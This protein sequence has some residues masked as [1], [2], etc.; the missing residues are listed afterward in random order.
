MYMD[1]LCASG[2]QKEKSEMT[3]EKKKQWHPAFFGALHLELVEN[4]CDLDFTEEFILNTMPLRVDTLIIKKR[5]NCE[6][7][8][9]IG[10]IFRT[11]NLV[12]YK[13]PKD[14]LNYNSFLKGLAYAYLYK[15]QEAYVGAIPLEEVTLSFIRERK[16]KK[17]LKR[18][19]G[20]D[21]SVEERY[22]GIYYISRS[23]DVSIQIIVSK[24]LNREN[25]I[26]IKALTEALNEI[27]AKKINYKHKSIER[28]R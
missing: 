19:I 24:D 10:K 9:E 6:I 27:E 1:F 15:C 11:H 4:K 22:K 21:F 20:E 14:T 25:H 26:W 5:H 13:S 12:E 2:E 23:G 18:L 3:K 28:F 16:P 8:N 17:L 7:K